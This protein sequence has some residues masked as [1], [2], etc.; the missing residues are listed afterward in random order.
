MDGDDDFLRPPRLESLLVFAFLGVLAL[1]PFPYG[2]NRPW[3]EL[4]LGLG[5]GAVLFAWSGLALTGVASAVHP[6]RRLALPALC[7]VAA[8]GWAF[9]QS[10]DLQTV[11]RLTGLDLSLLANPIWAKASAALGRDAGSYISVAPEATRHAIFTSVLSVGAFLLAF[12]LGRD[13]DRALTL[14]GGIVVIAV[15]YAAA[16]LASFYLQIDPQSF[17]MPDRR[18]SADLLAGPFEERNH[19]ATFLGLG[20]LAGMGLFVETVRPAVMWERGF[21]VMLRSLTFAMKG[22]N[23]LWLVATGVIIA[24]LLLT[25]A[26][27]G[28]IAFLIGTIA[29]IV[30][31]AVGRR[32]TAGEE[33]GQRAMTALL[34]LV[35]GVSI[36]VALQP[37][38]GRTGVE[39]VSDETREALVQASMN[40]IQS[41][42]LLGNGFGAFEAYYPLV[43]DGSLAAGVKEA[44]NDLLETLA[45]LGL[46][47][48]G[49][50]IAAPMLLAGM[51]FA[52][53]VIRR[54]DRMY[55]AIALAVS[56]LVGVHALIEFSLQIPAIAVT[57]A[58]LLGL[59]VAQSW[60]TNMDAVR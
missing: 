25:Q 13:R 15:I 6:I 57:F 43:A 49:A 58:A 30:A 23:L 51:C 60:R 14:L 39:G 41:A 54:R 59:G 44:N 50:F 35:L 56:V 19:F 2:A 47:A 22:V 21:R 31:L 37:L 4:A 40:A 5:L 52:G 8:L 27:G 10:V 1:A 34:V 53:C 7:I 55:P 16:A 46:L 18:A 38:L 12:E 20:A 48:G 26:R 42:P 9:A 3:A 29:L 17:V 11:A 28:I 32:W 33:R 24:V 36:G 45:D